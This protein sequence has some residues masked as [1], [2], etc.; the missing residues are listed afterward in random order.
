[1]ENKDENIIELYLFGKL[2]VHSTLVF[3]KRMQVDSQLTAQVEQMREIVAA[4]EK[5][6]EQ[7]ALAALQRVESE[8]ELRKI[9]N[10]AE[11]Q[12]APRKRLRRICFFQGSRTQT[13]GNG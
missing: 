3:E 11:S 12:I 9:I 1:M 7:G 10:R 13:D 6:G 5:R 4:F 8:E 2:D